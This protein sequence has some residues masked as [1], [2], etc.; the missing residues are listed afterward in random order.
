MATATNLLT[1]EALCQ[2]PSEFR[3]ELID[4]VVIELSPPGGVHGE[5]AVTISSLF[6]AKAQLGGL[7]RVMV[8]TGFVLRR[9]PDTVRSPDVTFV[10]AE[11]IPAGGLP[12]GYF[13]GA[14]DIAVEV[15]SPSNTPAEVQAKVREWIEAGTPLVLLAYPDSRSVH[16]VRSLRQRETPTEEDVLRIEDVLTGFS[17][18]A[19]DFFV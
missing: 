2:L 3:C 4:G 1:A 7:G 18:P 17:C 12:V 11:R 8:E 14:P 6:R 15:I 19:A 9:N 13:E 5:I 16:V 10:R